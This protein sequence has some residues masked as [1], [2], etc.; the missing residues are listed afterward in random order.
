MLPTY[1]DDISSPLVSDKLIEELGNTKEIQERKRVFEEYLS[2]AESPYEFYGFIFDR[3]GTEITEYVKDLEIT[4]LE[5]IVN[6]AYRWDE[7]QV[8]CFLLE[9][10]LNHTRLQTGPEYLIRLND[11][12]LLSLPQAGPILWEMFWEGTNP[13]FFSELC[14][15][16]S[17]KSEIIGT[18]EKSDCFPYE[19]NYQSV[20][21]RVAI[22]FVNQNA[23]DNSI[24]VLVSDFVDGYRHFNNGKYYD[25]VECFESFYWEHPDIFPVEVI[26]Q[27]AK[28]QIEI[29]W[30]NFAFHWVEKALEI[31]SSNE[32]AE[33]LKAKIFQSDKE[34]LDWIKKTTCEPHW[35]AD[36]SSIFAMTELI[37]R[38][39]GRMM[40][41]YGSLVNGYGRAVET[42][43]RQKLLPKIRQ[44][45]RDN[46]KEKN[47]GRRYVRCGKDNLFDDAPE[48]E[49]SLGKW[50][51]LIKEDEFY[52]KYEQVGE[53]YCCVAKFDNGILGYYEWSRLL[54][55]LGRAIEQLSGIRNRGSHGPSSDWEDVES[56]RDLCLRILKGIPIKSGNLLG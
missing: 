18:I 7:D 40:Q 51:T 53:F 48:R 24:D 14:E 44:W 52:K 29:G 8:A 2:E 23:V 19:A 17:W 39:H 34:Q 26:L 56:A 22:E 55:E 15:Y 36:C 47:N 12:N 45:I 27:I 28:C 11:P 6:N 20:F 9:V 41:D 1:R 43:L 25:A 33:A 31:N 10:A 21:R 13:T 37:Y 38:Y 30:R 35:T 42:Q 3:F 4:I 54:H 46:G 50:A 5:Y 32:E 49:F 16:Y